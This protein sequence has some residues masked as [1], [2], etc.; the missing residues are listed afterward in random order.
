MG[1]SLERML[2]PKAVCLHFAASNSREVVSMLSGL[3]QEEGFVGPTFFEAAMER[4]MV[5][6]T[7]LPLAGGFNAAIPHTDVEH[8]LKPGVALATLLEPVIFQNMIA[9]EEGVP[10]RLVFL[11][12]LNQPKAQVEMLQQIASVLQNP[13]V[14]EGLIRAPDLETVRELL[15]SEI[16]LQES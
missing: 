4:E 15:S 6:P 9:P 2:V 16:S 8:V 1:A 10:V 12:A 11:L 7:G 3:L 14:V 5:M 13:E